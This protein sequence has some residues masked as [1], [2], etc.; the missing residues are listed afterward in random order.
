MDLIIDTGKSGA[1][2]LFDGVEPVEAFLFSDAGDKGID[3]TAFYDFLQA[4]SV[5]SPEVYL[6]SIQAVSKPGYRTHPMQLIVVGQ[7]LACLYL[8]GL[9]PRLVA[10]AAWVPA[11]RRVCIRRFKTDGPAKHLSQIVAKYIF[12][13][14]AG[15]YFGR[16]Y[17]HDGVA[18][19]LAISL[20]VNSLYYSG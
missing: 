4:V 10:P 16:K 12:P 5:F 19:C 13:D 3:V 14:F 8:H 2:V 15:P 20:W 9:E 7:I 11:V 6:E 18:D 1:S 17:Y